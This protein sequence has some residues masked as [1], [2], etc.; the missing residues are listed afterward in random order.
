MAR[1]SGGERVARP[2]VTVMPDLRGQSLRKGLRLLQG[3]QAK[4][5][6]NG[7]GR[8][9]SQKPSPGSSLSGVGE[10]A[11]ILEKPEMVTPEVLAKKAASGR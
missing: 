10:V 1:R 9:V 5:V 7:T 2:L 11:L 4:I 8:I 3:V 6:I